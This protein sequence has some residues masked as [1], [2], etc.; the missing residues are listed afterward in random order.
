MYL[1]DL[2]SAILAFGIVFWLA[3]GPDWLEERVRQM[4]LD[5]DLKEQQII[6]LKRKNEQ[7]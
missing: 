2:S 5:N 1:F 6:D 7:P 4:K 3:G